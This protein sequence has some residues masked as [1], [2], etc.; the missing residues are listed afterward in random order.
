MNLLYN[1]IYINLFKEADLSLVKAASVFTFRQD[2]SL[3]FILP[4]KVKI[5]SDKELDA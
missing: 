4:E 2:L 3:L 1:T 5:L